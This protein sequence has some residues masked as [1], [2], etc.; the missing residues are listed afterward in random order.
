MKSEMKIRSISA[1][2]SES[3][4]GSGTG[5][6]SGSRSSVVRLGL[7][8]IITLCL[9]FN[10]D[11]C[12]GLYSG[13][14]RDIGV[15]DIEY[16]QYPLDRNNLGRKRGT[17]AELE[18]QTLLNLN[19]T[20]PNVF[21]IS[22]MGTAPSPPTS[23]LTAL[24]EVRNGDDFPYQRV[25]LPWQFNFF[26]IGVDNVFASP[27]GELHMTPLPPCRGCYQFTSDFNSS[28]Y[29]VIAGF[30]SDLLPAKYPGNFSS[31]TSSTTESSV[32]VQYT[33]IPFYSNVDNNTFGMT[34]YND[35]SM[36]VYWNQVFPSGASKYTPLLVGFRNFA[37]NSLTSFT[38][39]Q[40]SLGRTQFGTTIAGIY[41]LK[42]SVI[43]GSSFIA[44]P[45]STVWC[46]TPS[47]MVVSALTTLQLSPLSISCLSRIEV[48][49]FAVASTAALVTIDLSASSTSLVACTEHISTLLCDLSQ[50]P[51]NYQVVSNVSLGIAW[52]VSDSNDAYQNFSLIDPIVIELS[53]LES[54]SCHVNY[55]IPRC[56]DTCSLCTGDYSCLQLPCNNATDPIL[57]KY[58]V[59][60][61]TCYGTHSFN[62][63]YY[64]TGNDKCC[65]EEQVDCLGVCYGLYVTAPGTN[66]VI[67]CCNPDEID[68]YGIC[69]G[70]NIPDAC[71]VCG[72]SDIAGTTC[73]SGVVVTTNSPLPNTLNANLVVANETQQSSLFFINVTNTNSTSIFVK[74]VVADVSDTAKYAP[75]ITLPVISA[76]VEGEQSAVFAVNISLAGLVTG[77][78]SSGW[79]VKQ[80]YVTSIREHSNAT[81]YYRVYVYPAVEDCNAVVEYGVC[82]MLPACIFCDAYD[83][84]RILLE[85][86]DADVLDSMDGEKR[87]LYPDLLPSQL[88]NEADY[89]TGFCSSGWNRSVCHGHAFA[90][91]EANTAFV[92]S[93]AVATV[94]YVCTALVLFVV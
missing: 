17:L 29:G 70:G 16:S 12:Y 8:L 83:H 89:V 68:C 92:H 18:S 57:Y 53:A 65:E 49:V 14:S 63:L 82:E 50:L 24:H 28:L 60:N 41:P 40:L 80:I 15:Y 64:D 4:S 94:M 22:F 76:T 87:R 11:L 67:Q 44:C 26:G 59:C 86:G 51:S 25:T 73:H 75:S 88:T 35:S 5:Y 13:H 42:S 38:T 37:N 47:V 32:T 34:L 71:G 1:S 7:L 85:Y 39:S 43:S 19:H 58:P 66:G 30:C 84:I 21:Y 46:A 33:N 61:N 45:I 78:D 23:D 10:V 6:G 74:L 90:T 3:K 36:E 48:V 91:N 81:L 2:L 9:A 31:I 72:G 20:S 77:A 27:N 55:D 54:A 52:R 62:D 56:G 93:L 79:M 69:G